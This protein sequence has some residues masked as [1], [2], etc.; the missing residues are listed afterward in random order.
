MGFFQTDDRGTAGSA[1]WAGNPLR[2]WI[3]A[4]SRDKPFK[5]AYLFAVDGIPNLQAEASSITP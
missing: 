4:R 2:A 5:N 1:R 3:S